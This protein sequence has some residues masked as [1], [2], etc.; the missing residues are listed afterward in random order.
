MKKILFILVT[1]VILLSATCHKQSCTN[2]YSFEIP[3]S[4]TE[5]D[6]FRIGDTIWL[7]SIITNKL[8]DKNSMSNIDISNFDFKINCGLFRVDTSAV[9]QAEPYFKVINK[10]GKLDIKYLS[11]IIE[12][13]VIYEKGIE[14]RMFKIGLIPQKVGIFKISFFNLTEDLENVKVTESECNSN[15]KLH[16]NMNSGRDFNYY[17]IQKSPRSIVSEEEYKKDGA[18]AFKIIK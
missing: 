3:F 7:N 15:I 5:L 12:S 6:S 10:I 13:K 14:N 11:S 17:L 18:Y 8:V 2:D 1:S 16:Y 4:I 9:E